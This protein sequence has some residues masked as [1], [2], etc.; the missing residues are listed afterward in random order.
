MNK[1]I[2]TV[3]MVKTQVLQNNLCLYGSDNPADKTENVALKKI[4]RTTMPIGNQ[5]KKNNTRLQKK[6]TNYNGIVAKAQPITTMPNLLINFIIRTNFHSTTCLNK[7]LKT[8]Q[9]C[10]KL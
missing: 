3:F 10:R 2:A 9:H 1:T 4:P 7:I 5:Y 6:T 8:E